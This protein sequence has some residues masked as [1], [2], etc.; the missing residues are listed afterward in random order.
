[1]LRKRITGAALGLALFV[2]LSPA[3]SQ[4]IPRSWTSRSGPAA[5]SLFVKIEGW[6]NLLLNRAGRPANGEKMACAIDPNGTPLCE[7]AEGDG[8]TPAEPP[9]PTGP[10]GSD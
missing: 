1:M 2:A 5:A 4:A 6:W 3:P 9:P 8:T 7:P 10:A